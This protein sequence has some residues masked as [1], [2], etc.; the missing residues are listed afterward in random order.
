M[1]DVLDVYEPAAL[2]VL[3]PEATLHQVADGF[4]FT[5]GPV[6]DF[7][8][9]HLV[10]SDIPGDT[11]YR[12]QPDKG[13][14]IYRKP[15]MFSNG[16]TLDADGRLIVCEHRTRRVA[17]EVEPGRFETV[18]DSYAGQRLN[19]P[20]DVIIAPDGSLVFT[21]PHYDIGEGFGGPAEQVQAH[22]GLYRVPPGAGEP[23]LLVDDFGGPNGLAL[24]PTGDRLYVDDTERAHIRSFAVGDNWQLTGGDVLIE[25]AGDGEGVL[26][27]LK[28]DEEGTIYCT[29]PGGIYICHPNGA[30]LGRI[31]IPEVTANLAWGDSDARTLYITASDKLFRLRTQVTGF[32]PHRDLARRR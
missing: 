21:D 30:L 4:V 2:K 16:T 12:Y 3:S 10:F 22:R 6:W 26:D 9:G 29:G 32:A 25:L 17:R 1:S 27:G 23:Q 24:A 28:V 19:A 11:M 20:N 8:A 18:A 31:R 7:D 5:E 15:S 13:V 14:T